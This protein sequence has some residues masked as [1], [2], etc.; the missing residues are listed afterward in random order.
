MF[1]ITK[2][3]ISISSALILFGLVMSILPVCCEANVQDYWGENEQ[4]S[5]LCF[6]QSS[7]FLFNR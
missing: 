5:A 1:L 3:H 2:T 7:P 4:D 6:S